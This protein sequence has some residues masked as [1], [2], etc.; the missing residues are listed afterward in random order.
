MRKLERTRLLAGVAVAL[1]LVPSAFSQAAEVSLEEIIVTAQKRVERLQDVPL[2]ITAIPT[3]QIE[4]MGASTFTD[5]ARTVPGLS[6]IDRGPGRTSIT[7]R[8]ITTG[9]DQGKQALVGVYFDD[10]PVSAPS[11]QPDLNLFDIERVEVLRGPQGTLY[12]AGSMGGAIKLVPQKP[13][14]TEVA[15]KAEGTLSSTRHGGENYRISGMINAPLV[16]GKVA[17]RL[18]GYYRNESGYINNAT[19]GKKDVNDEE[20]YGGRAMIRVVPSDDL[21]ITGTVL[22]QNTDV[23]GTQEANLLLGPLTQDRRISETREDEFQQYN[24]TID[25]DFGWANLVSSSTYFTRD[26]RESRDI[27]AFLGGVSTV[28]Q[29][30]T[31]PIDTFSQEVRLAS[32]GEGP[33][34]WLVGAFY[35][36]Q[37]D[38][39]LQDV[40]H[41]GFGG[42]PPST[43]LL[44]N[45]IN[46]KL[47]Q[48][49]FFGE[50]TY[51]L[52]PKLHATV[53]FRWFDVSQSFDKFATGI[54]VGGDQTD[55]GKASQRK[56]N[57]KF[58]LSYDVNDD[59]LMY[60]QAVQ[61]FRVGGPNNT[62][63][64]DPLTGESSQT[65]YDS[66][67][68][69]NYEVGMKTSWLD[70]R[71]TL[72][73]SLFY[74]DWTDIQVTIFRTDGF[75]YI[76]N[77]AKASSKGAEFELSARPV[78]NLD[79]RAAFSYTDASLEQ[80]VP[81]LGGLKG[82]RVPYVPRYT[83]SASARYSF[84]V[85][86]ALNG[87]AQ[88]DYQ[89]T[90]NS[91]NA[92][93]EAAADLQGAY[94]L[95][96]LRAGIEADQWQVILFVDNVWDERADLF[97]D[98]LLGDTRANVNRPRTIGVTLRSNF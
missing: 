65:Q 25:Y 13:N 90:G 85:T 48:I 23:G 56:I 79:L 88:F 86:S 12:G 94:D 5:Y 10:M 84:A 20:T 44:D 55:M 76:G 26:F 14:M 72:N 38:K 93:N 1:T 67:T 24:L 52:T 91:Y 40:P 41:D 37:K 82:D 34:K 89:H 71:L 66:D 64:P 2:S 22:F 69:W 75:S 18:V 81:G 74:I 58:G 49:A 16:E 27:S 4:K 62:L 39:L 43:I 95:G 77:A 28:W 7:I 21:T 11:F 8:G 6:F 19:L 17:A 53:G 97:L 29:V 59:V 46:N 54:I 50:G 30:N 9:A 42:L 63:P 60:A 35:T 3:D 61:G 70:N 92:F 68:L 36:H 45:N 47:E 33:F 78:E 57:P 32:N 80:D 83:Y 96:N 98:T 31:L 87:F 73:A 51:D 15:G